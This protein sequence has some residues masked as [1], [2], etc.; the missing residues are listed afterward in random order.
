ME[1][2]IKIIC[3]NKD[4]LFDGLGVTIILGFIGMV[5]KKKKSKIKINQKIVGKI[6]N[7]NKDDEV[8]S[9]ITQTIEG[10]GSNQAGG[11]INC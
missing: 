5:T 6:Q 8:D 9:D 1:K 10:D 4:W 3:D 11:D 2:I 7:Y